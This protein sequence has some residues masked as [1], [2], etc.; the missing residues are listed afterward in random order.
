M[1]DRNKSSIKELQTTVTVKRQ[2]SKGQWYKTVK[3]KPKLLRP[4]WLFV[5]PWTVA[6]HGIFQARVLEW[7]AISFSRGSSQPRDWT[8]VSCTAADALPSKTR[9]KP[10]HFS[11]TQVPTILNT[12]KNE[13]VKQK[14]KNIP[15]GQKI[16][17]KFQTL[18]LK[19]CVCQV[20]LIHLNSLPIFPYSVYHHLLFI[21]AHRWLKRQNWKKLLVT[22]ITKINSM[23]V[24][25]EQ[26]EQK[27]N[28]KQTFLISR[29]TPLPLTPGNHKFLF[30][31]YNSISVL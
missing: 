10:G 9:G 20:C 5:T 14:E 2:F 22:P 16:Q 24:W 18:K 6:H 17:S 8:S 27:E 28:R 3:V 1:Q 23:L 30:Y 19:Y 12:D 21:L 25:Q 13:K 29:F 7:V 31:I 26:K 15:H 4:V 11:K